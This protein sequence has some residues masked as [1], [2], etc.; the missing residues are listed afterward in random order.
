MKILHVI[1]GLESGGAERTLQRMVECDAGNAAVTHSI[2]SLTGTGAIGPELQRAGIDVQALGLHSVLDLPRVFWRL[3]GAIRKT[4]P[5]IVQTWMYHADFLGGL[6]AWL[7]GRYP[8]V[9]C[10]RTT[11]LPAGKRSVTAILRW[12]CARLSHWIPDQIVCAAQ[13]S[14]ATHAALGYDAAK[15]VVVANGYDFSRFEAT[16]EER[17][18]W[19]EQHGIAT[20]EMVVG[21]IGRWHAD[22]DPDNFIRMAGVLGRQHARLRFLMVGRGLHNTNTALMHSLECSGMAAR[23]VLVGERKDV[24]QCLAAMDIFCLHSRTEAFPNVLAE[25]MAMG[26]PCVTTDV[27]DAALLLNDCGHVVPK[28]DTAALAQGVTRLLQMEPADRLALGARARARVR[29]RFTIAAARAG[30][31][32]VYQRLLNGAGH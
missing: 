16:L 9:W 15:M 11:D 8:V 32:S 27:G 13:A 4:R 29:G 19:R 6:A 21:S 17:R 31:E 3:L 18:A 23:F 25:A 14:R 10:V 2:V 24:P 22:K 5:D 12:A 30:F 1:V 20:E 28:K 7:A 26:L